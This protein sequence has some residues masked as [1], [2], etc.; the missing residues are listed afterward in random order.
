MRF[1][2]SIIA[3]L[4]VFV[5]YSS[6]GQK[7]FIDPGHG[8]SANGGNPDGRTQTEIHTALATGLKL[9]ALVDNDCSWQSL[10]SRTTNIG[11]WVTIGTRQNMSDSWGADYF[12]SIHCNAGGGTGTETFWCNQSS[13]PNGAAN[14]NFA[15]GIQS[16]MAAGGQWFDRRVV[17]EHGFLGYH[18]GVLTTNQ[19]YSCLSEIGFVDTPGDAAKLNSNSWRDAFAQAYIDA[20]ET[21]MGTT[22]T[23]SCPGNLNLPSNALSGTYISGNTI[24]S[25][26]QVQNG[27]NCV[28]DASSAVNLDPGFDA[29]PGSTL[30]AKIGGCQ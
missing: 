14:I 19:A 9:K 28:L 22:C 16:S 15:E 11:G 5:S 6:N 20:L 21:H 23:S 30:D 17:E 1:I 10:M 26:G 12:I 8:Y 13:S 7:I 29:V 18:F 25:T 4:I 24:T 2:L 27:S 3:I